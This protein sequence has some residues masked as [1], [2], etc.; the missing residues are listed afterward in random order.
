MI[1]KCLFNYSLRKGA[2]FYEYV[3]GNSASPAPQ[4]PLP[5]VWGVRKGE[6]KGSACG[7]RAACACVWLRA[8]LRPIFDGIGYVLEASH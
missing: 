8:A 5:P 3:G 4:G 7:L 6:G 1:V 2:D